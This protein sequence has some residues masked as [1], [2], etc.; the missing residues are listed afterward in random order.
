MD[1]CGVVGSGDVRINN[2]KIPLGGGNGIKYNNSLDNT[3][4]CTK[5]TPKK[6]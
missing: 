6:C 5:N 1:K 2:I 3:K 4:S